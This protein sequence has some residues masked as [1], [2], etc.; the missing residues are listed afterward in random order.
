MS[1]NI[2]ILD[3]NISALCLDKMLPNVTLTTEYEKLAQK[4]N[5]TYKDFV[6]MNKDAIRHAFISEDEKEQ[7]L[8]K[9][10]EKLNQLS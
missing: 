7:L 4:L 5:F 8:Q 6:K 1:K 9:Y 3:T 2:C 10:D